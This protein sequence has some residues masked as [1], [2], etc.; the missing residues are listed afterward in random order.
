MRTSRPAAMLGL[1]LLLWTSTSQSVMMRVES[2]PGVFSHAVRLLES[3]TC[4]P[5]RPVWILKDLRLGDRGIQ[6]HGQTDRMG[7]DQIFLGNLGG[8]RKSETGIIACCKFG[9][10]TI[11]VTF[12]LVV[13]RLRLIGARRWDEFLVH[14]CKDAITDLLEFTFTFA[15]Y[16]LACEASCS[17][18]L[19]FSFCSTLVMTHHAARRLP[20]AFLYT[21]HNR[22]HY[23]ART[24]PHQRHRGWNGTAAPLP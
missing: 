4:R 11:I 12:H 9:K 2:L 19:N 13:K 24:L 20:T 14:E 7:H 17:P 10:V 6:C 1:C 8:F 23:S 15:T 18:P 3:S 16:S 22:F 21:S 5:A